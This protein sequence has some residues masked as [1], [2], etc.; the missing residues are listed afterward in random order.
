METLY[1]KLSN[2]RYEPAEVE[3]GDRLPDG[4]WY[5][6]TKKSSRG[7]TN[8]VFRVGDITNP[9]DITNKVAL[10]PLQDKLAEYLRRLNDSTSEEFLQA[11]NQLGGFIIGNISILGISMNDLTTLILNKIADDL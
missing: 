8:L 3:M 1:R 4:L 9:K 6:Q 10:M 7:F 11:K 2:G 5:I